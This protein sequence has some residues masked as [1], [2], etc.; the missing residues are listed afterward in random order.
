MY[1]EKVFGVGENFCFTNLGVYECFILLANSLF[2]FLLSTKRVGGA[3]FEVDEKDW[4][5][6][7]SRQMGKIF[8]Q[9]KYL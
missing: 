4:Q 8:D 2:F 5:I 3:P 6:S 1:F 7:Y 9:G